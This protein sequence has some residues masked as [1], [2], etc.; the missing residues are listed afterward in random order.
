MHRR[1]LGKTAIEV[2]RLGLG[3]V[4]FGREIDQAAS[5]AV[6]DRAIEAGIN[7]LD[8]AEAYG[9]RQS[10]EGRKA[11]LGTEDVREAMTFHPVMTIDEVLGFALDPSPTK[12]EV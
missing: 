8:T 2:S 7:L 10:L 1:T 12:T 11:R 4:T 5:F 3:C 9:G 6:L